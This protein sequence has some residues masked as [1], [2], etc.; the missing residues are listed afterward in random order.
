MMTEFQKAG[1]DLNQEVSGLSLEISKLPYA[2]LA[3]SLDAVRQAGAPAWQLATAQPRRV[4]SQS[5]T[6]SYA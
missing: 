6:A 4:A 1:I 5:I 3:L 2:R